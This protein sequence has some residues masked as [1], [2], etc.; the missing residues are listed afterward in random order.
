MQ[1][2]MELNSNT[3]LCDT[4]SSVLG[5]SSVE[6]P[7][8]DLNSYA[9]FDTSQQDGEC[10]NLFLVP[11]VVS[12]RSSCFAENPRSFIDAWGNKESSVSS[13]GKL[14]PSSLT[15]TMGGLGYNSIN[16]EIG[17]SITQMGSGYYE[18]SSKFLDSWHIPPWV[19]SPPPGGPLGEVLGPSSLT[20]T[21]SAVSNQS[22]PITGNGDT[23]SLLA[24]T[25]SS[26]SMVLQKTHT[27]LSADSNGSSSSPTFGS[28]KEK[29][30]IALF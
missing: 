1:S 28:S 18:N 23:E 12:F 3:S 26:S 14:S 7:F 16:N 13:I 15:L 30:E 29:A 10:G 20:A 9:N 24:T 5:H 22:S 2:K 19:G 4:D 21:P 27:S 8:L 25:M 17:S 11:D 6:E